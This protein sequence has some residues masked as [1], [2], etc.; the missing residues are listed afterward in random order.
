MD[1]CFM[2]THMHTH[3]ILLADSYMHKDVSISNDEISM[4]FM[5]IT[6][7]RTNA[8]SIATTIIPLSEH[9]WSTRAALMYLFEY[10]CSY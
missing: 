7:D 1:Q 2:W 9:S 8:V 10:A 4:T 6:T 3:S 5:A